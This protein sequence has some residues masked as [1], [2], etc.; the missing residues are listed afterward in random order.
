M[1]WMMSE[2]RIFGL[3]LLLLLLLSACITLPPGSP[4]SP[5]IHVVAAENFY[6][7]VARQ[8]GGAY[9]TVTS[10]I[11]NPNVDP[12]AY[13]SSVQTAIAV[14]NARL[15]IENGDGYDS[16]MSKILAGSPNPQRLVLTAYNVAPGKLPDNPHVWYSIDNMQAIAQA[17]TGDLQQLDPAHTATFE[18]NLQA[19]EQSL[20]TIR[21]KISGI[22]SKFAST[23]VGLTE[24]I[25]LYQTGL[26]GLDVLTPF[27]FQK[28]VAEGN[29][30]PADA[31][32]TTENQVTHH[33][34]RVLIY[35]EQTIQPITTR[36]Q[37][38]A[39]A[40]HIPIVAVTETMPPDKTYQ[41]WMLDQ[42]NSLEQAL[43]QSNG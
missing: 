36:L 23:P 15:V 32:V 41:T 6:G 4:G 10:I 3:S 40:Q 42:L 28:A 43:Q 1:K 12:H 33:Q 9:V 27:E 25:F 8:I 37:S 38:E 20:S 39:Q 2:G 35:N 34:I 24:T 22:Y 7:D 17:I 26:L 11:S 30:P 31:V 18:S 13:E 29:D 19:F 16:W 14:Y 21:Q 5:V